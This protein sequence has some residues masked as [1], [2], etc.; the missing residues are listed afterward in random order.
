MILRVILAVSASVAIAYSAAPLLA[1]HVIEA[2]CCEN[3][4]HCATGYQCVFKV[5]DTCSSPRTGFCEPVPR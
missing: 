4:G 2:T 1:A 5:G 3:D